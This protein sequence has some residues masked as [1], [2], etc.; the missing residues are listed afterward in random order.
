MASIIKRN[1]KY[2]VV[3]NYTDEKGKR[4]QK[5]ATF[6]TKKEA[7]EYKTRVELAAF[8][9]APLV[10]PASKTVDELMDEYI[11]NYGAE[12]WSFNYFDRVKRMREH[13]I[14]PYIG[15]MKLKDISPRVIE[16]YYHTLLQKE[17]ALSTKENKRL[18]TPNTVKNVHKLLHSAFVQA[19]RWEMIPSNPFDKAVP[20]KSKEHRRDIWDMEDLRKA[21][22][23]CDDPILELSINLAF[24][25]SLRMG[26]ILGLT[27]DCVHISDDLVENNS[28]WI[29]INKQLQ[30]VT[31]EAINSVITEDI[32]RKF[33]VS[34]TKRQSVLVL[35]PPKTQSSIRKI[36]LP[37]TVASM[38][39]ERKEVVKEYKDFLGDDYHDYDLVICYENGTPMEGDKI[40]DGLNRLIQENGLKPVVFHSLRHSSTTYKLKLSGGDIKAVQGD[41]GHAQASMITDR[42]AHV[43]DDDRR[44]NAEKFEEMFYQGQGTD[45]SGKDAEDMLR[46]MNK[47]QESPELL[48]LLK[49]LMK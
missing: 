48:E 23:A 33:P 43:L 49:G 35:K 17:S 31:N 7:K 3:I 30:R 19:E 38:L 28:A 40:R 2:A 16:A 39:K 1:G 36:Y 15:T 18:V 8:S 6:E 14:S 24:S 37:R 25:C 21:L 34:S 47:L 44:I 32:I 29:M 26:E 22:N 42:Y 20:P 10:F 4:K 46:I 12:K 5:W 41:T 45:A 11:K 9:G 13:Y 27:W